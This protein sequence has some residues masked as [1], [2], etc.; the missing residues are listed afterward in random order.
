MPASSKLGVEVHVF[1]NGD[2]VHITQ[3]E[4][5]VGSWIEY[6]DGTRQYYSRGAFGRSSVLRI[7][8]PDGMV[9]HYEGARGSER[10]VRVE[11]ASQRRT[12]QRDRQPIA[13]H[14]AQSSTSAR[15]PPELP[16]MG[17]HGVILLGRSGR[18]MAAPQPEP[19]AKSSTPSLPKLSPKPPSSSRRHDAVPPGNQ[20]KARQL[21]M[22][23]G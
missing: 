23:S 21:V 4:S 20:S 16:R 14:A 18:S 17:S 2:K 8:Y 11:H 1:D 3:S 15:N 13:R 6:A 12:E 5:D 9:V 10:E 19:S 22:S 7:E